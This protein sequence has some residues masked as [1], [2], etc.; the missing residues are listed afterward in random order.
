MELAFAGGVRV[1]AADADGD[2][3]A[4]IIAGAGAGG[5]PD[6]KVFNGTD[7][8]VLRSIFAFDPA[9]TGGVFVG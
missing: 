2:G 4:D 7:G 6:M 8:H 5:G 9:F 3:R 1:A